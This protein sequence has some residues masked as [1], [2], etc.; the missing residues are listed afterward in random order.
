MV[1]QQ[2]TQERNEIFQ[3]KCRWLVQHQFHRFLSP[4]RDDS[5]T[6]SSPALFPGSGGSL[7]IS[8]VGSVSG[9]R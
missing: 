5:I 3:K 4:G 2:I 1:I 6:S 7:S 8:F 9:K